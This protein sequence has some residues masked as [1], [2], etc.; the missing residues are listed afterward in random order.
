MIICV[1]AIKESENGEALYISGKEGSFSLS[2]SLS[3]LK[4]ILKPSEEI[5]GSFQEKIFACLLFIPCPFVGGKKSET[6]RWNGT[7][8]DSGEDVR[9]KWT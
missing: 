9:C 6:N 2:L 3:P 7:R 4:L 5:T 8:G 1:V